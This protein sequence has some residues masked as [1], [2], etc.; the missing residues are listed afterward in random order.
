MHEKNN[1]FAE[2]LKDE[3]KIEIGKSLKLMINVL[4]KKG[5]FT[6]ENRQRQNIYN[7]M[8]KYFNRDI[9]TKQ[10]IFDYKYVPVGNPDFES[11]ELRIDNLLVRLNKLK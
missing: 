4:I 7:A 9:G 10:S 2:L 5:M 8:K 3:F 11:F 6:I 1:E